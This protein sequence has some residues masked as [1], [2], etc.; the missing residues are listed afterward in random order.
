MHPLDT[1]RRQL[2]AA[3]GGVGALATGSWIERQLSGSPQFTHYTYAAT[4][5]D[6]G[7][8]V[9]EV[10]WYATYN[11]Q[12][13][14]TQGTGDE[15]NASKVLDPDADPRY[16]P[17]ATGPVVSLSNVLPGDSGRLVVGLR[18][19]RD[20]RVDLTGAVRTSESGQTEPESSVDSS[21]DGELGETIRV[22]LWHD[23]GPLG[24]GGCDGERGL[25]DEPIDEGSLVDVI[26]G[27]EPPRTIVDC[28]SADAR[29]CIGFDWSFPTSASNENQTDGV[30]F[31]LEFRATSCEK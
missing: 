7:E 3:I 11:G 19:S 12:L 21:A 18:A 25:G 4:P 30:E 2:L 17:D 6:T 24:V 29:R 16:V 15:A 28:L 23:T 26:R 20:V 1:R 13:T 27:L 10:A 5:E 31:D 8:E 9:L 14:I 22:D